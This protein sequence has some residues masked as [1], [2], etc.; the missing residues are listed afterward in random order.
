[1]L[2]FFFPLLLLRALA[3]T[4]RFGRAVA[5]FLALALGFAAFG[6]VGAGLGGVGAGTGGAA[7]VG[8]GVQGSG[9]PNM[10]SIVSSM[11]MRSA[12]ACPT[13]PSRPRER[14]KEIRPRCAHAHA[15]RGRPARNWT[16]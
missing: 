1:A 2:A 7:G 11:S 10:R 9:S 4:L 14:K 3:F 8:V 6:A 5:F 13:L 16:R 15:P 12:R